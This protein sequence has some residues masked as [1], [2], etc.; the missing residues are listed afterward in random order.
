MLNKYAQTEKQKEFTKSIKNNTVSFGIG[1]AGT[2]K[3]YSALQDAFNLHFEEPTLYRK[4]III[5]SIVNTRDIGFLPG[6]EEEKTA[7]F[8]E[9]YEKLIN[10]NIFKYETA[11]ENL[12]ALKLLEFRTSSHLRGL[13]FDNSIVIVDESQNFIFHELETTFTR[14][15][16]N[17]KY[18]FIG[19]TVQDDLKHQR[20]KS[21]LQEFAAIF[22]SM[23]ES[24]F[25]PVKNI[26]KFTEDDIVRN[27]II[28][29]YLKAKNRLGIK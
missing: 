8:E 14:I 13:T 2:G 15:G 26:I 16:D 11:Y 5:R 10:K 20:E 29:F 18:I 6:D 7:A 22:E 27:D 9:P 12:K 4:I 28:K 1:C 25:N 19:D 23:G 21:G 24:E 3:T 17:S